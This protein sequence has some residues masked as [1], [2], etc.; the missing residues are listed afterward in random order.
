MGNGSREPSQGSR[1]NKKKGE[2][3]MKLYRIPN[4]RIAINL[5]AIRAIDTD[6]NPQNENV[7]E[8]LKGMPAINFHLAGVSESIVFK[9]VET[10]NKYFNKLIKAIKNNE[11]EKSQVRKDA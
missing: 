3:I 2:K 8:D 5:D 7:P 10:R 9:T 1:G 11:S 4:S 6:D